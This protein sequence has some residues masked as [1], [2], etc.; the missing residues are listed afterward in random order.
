MSARPR[1]GENRPESPA[2]DLLIRNAEWLV[3]L[4]EERRIIRDG[5][6]AIDGAEIV[7]VGKSD[8]IA[9]SYHPRKIIDAGDKLVLPGLID[10]HVHNSQQLGR[11]LADG[12][13]IPIHLLQRL[14]GYEAQLLS[15]DA[16]WAATNCH[17][18]MIR[19][20]TTCFLDPGNYFPDEMAR[21]L[22]ESGLRGVIARIAFDVHTTAIGD[23]ARH[24]VRE[25]ADEALARAQETIDAYH[26]AHDGRTR[27]WIGLR[28]PAVCSDELIR[29]AKQTADAN[30]VGLVLHASEARDEV[31][32]SRVKFG[33]P[34]VERL[35]E[36]GALG[37]NVLL[38]HMGWASPRELALTLRHGACVCCTPST[39][40]RAGMGSMEFGRFPELL[41]LGATVALG[42]DSAMSSNYVDIVRQM[43]LASGAAK[44]QRLDPM[45]LPPETVIEMATLHGAR[46]LLWDE[47]IGSIETGKKADI[48]LFDTNKPEWQPVLNPLANLV[49]A[50]RGGADTVVCNGQV[51]MEKGVVLSI[52]EERA[53]FE[54]KTRGRRIAERSGLLG[55]IQPRW[56][57]I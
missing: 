24:V 42:S 51:L 29:K 15:D 4:D 57:I 17:L 38:I 8:E 25:T 31:V 48:S 9:G 26:G 44:S 43:T 21:T 7:A 30:G 47:Q 13:D 40:F 34:D 33:M 45:V 6:V 5:A 14:Y 39:G 27:V 54:A 49:Y 23:L 11:G 41:E 35:A 56:P 53:L 12:C 3:T 46:A 37:P 55:A 18:E 2:I 32:A 50:S 1:P 28:I 36:L 16:Y 52:D 10:T 22:G 19:A 20:G